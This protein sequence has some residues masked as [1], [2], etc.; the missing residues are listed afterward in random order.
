MEHISIGVYDYDGNKLCDLYDSGIQ[1]Q[2]Q[3]YNISYTEELNGW[4]NLSFS[5][6]FVIDQ[7]QNFRWDYIRSEYQI[8]LDID[9]AIE[10]FLIQKPKATKDTKYIINNVD[11]PHISTILK[12]KNLYLTFD[13]ETG[14][15]PIDELIE[16]ALSNTGWELGECDTLYERDGTTEKVRSLNSDGKKGAYQ[17][18]TDICNLFKAFPIYHGDTKTVDIHALNNKGPMSEI[19]IGKNLNAI[20]TDYSTEN[21]ITRLYVEGEYG[22]YGYVGIDD[23]NPTGLPYLLNFDYYKSIGTFTAAHQTAQ[24]AYISSMGSV[25]ESIREKSQEIATAEDRLNTLW[26]QISYVVYT[27]DN[28]IIEKTIPGGTVTQEQETISEGDTLYVMKASGNYRVVTAGSGGS[29]SWEND[30]TMAVKFVTLP[31]GLIGSKQVAIESKQQIVATLTKDK[32]NTVDPIQ[33]QNIQNQIDAQNTAIQELYSGYVIETLVSGGYYTTNGETVNITSVTADG[34]WK[35]CKVQCTEGTKFVISGH[36][37]TDQLLWCFVNANNSDISAVPLLSSEASAEAANEEITAPSSTTHLICNFDADYTSLLKQHILSGDGLYDEMR[38]AVTIVI[39]LDGLQDD[40]MVLK[41]NQLEIEATFSEA[42]GDMLRDGYWSDNNYAPGQETNLYQDAIDVINQMAKPTVTYTFSQVGISAVIGFMEGL[43]EINDKVNVWDIELK[44]NDIVYVS[45]RTRYLD[46]SQ[47]DTFDVTNEDPALSGQSFESIMSRISQLADLLNQ[48]NTLYERAGAIT[49]SGTIYAQ[50]LNGAIDVLKNKLSST[51]SNWYTDDSG[52]IIF[53][54]ASGDSAMML[55]GGG[56]MIA[57]GKTQD[58]D[59]NW[60]TAADGKGIVAD[61]I[62][63]GF[64]SADRIEAGSITVNKLASDVGSSLDLSSNES[65]TSTVSS[66]INSKIRVSA[67]APTNP[68]VDVVWIQPVENGSDIVRRWTGYEWVESTLSQA[69]ITEIKSS[70]AQTQKDLTI[71]FQTA[72]ANITG[73][74]NN[75][76]AY[77]NEVSVYQRFSAN[78]LELGRTDSRFKAKLDNT[79][80]AFTQDGEEVAYVSNNK[81]YITEAQVTNTLSVG[82]DSHG[83]FDWVTTPSGMGLR[84]RG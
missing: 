38:E 68:A 65:V 64:L 25:A 39:A 50:R 30:D 8:R 57:D 26:G 11:C 19:Y 37:G 13:D 14:V 10:W 69:D 40:L 43:P 81:M 23:V 34:G 3:A 60:R 56:W 58:G 62:T 75:L 20:T 59:W 22:D 54:S 51:V 6:P 46:K 1:A 21:L 7:Q 27:L 74:S 48:K 66:M 4:K 55:T 2:G 52:A 84:W 61:R 42:M 63:T 71:S 28:G 79:K 67:E 82:T 16:R 78:G 31:S 49:A 77:K 15:G 76:N 36:G 5:L 12:T 18:I 80:L 70:I 53:E 24:D 29:V 35:N 45:K 9:D 47:K 83:F 44:L 17:M 41:S 33:R 32:N 73:V 72:E